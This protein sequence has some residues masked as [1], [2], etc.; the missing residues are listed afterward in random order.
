M[1]TYKLGSLTL[2]PQLISQPN[3]LPST[4]AEESGDENTKPNLVSGYSDSDDAVKGPESPADEF[5]GPVSPPFDGPVS[6]EEGAPTSPQNPEQGPESPPYRVASDC[7]DQEASDGEGNCV[8][9]EDKEV[10]E[11]PE[12]ESDQEVNETEMCEEEQDPE[13]EQL[14]NEIRTVESLTE[15]VVNSGDESEQG[16]PSDA[17]GQEEDEAVEEEQA[18]TSDNEEVAVTSDNE[19]AAVTSDNEEAAGASD[20]EEAAVRSDNEELAAMSDTE[21]QQVMS[22][23]EE[24]V[25]R[26]DNESESEALN[27][28]DM[29]PETVGDEVEAQPEERN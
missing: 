7:S 10:S 2:L 29:E 20:N 21:E 16:V 5:T 12:A 17:E 26:S 14:E 13:M 15:Q 24:Q 28:A 4:G 6:P 18:V 8:I 27:E 23:N 1:E 19:E 3:T 22:E 11:G 9:D 25:T